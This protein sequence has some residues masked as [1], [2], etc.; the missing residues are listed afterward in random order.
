MG[1]AKMHDGQI[2][3]TNGLMRRL[4]ESQFP[5][6]SALTIRSVQ[7]SGTDH[8]LYRVGQ[9]LVARLPIVDWAVDQVD[10]DQRWLPVLA[11]HLTLRVPVP[12]AVGQPGEGYPWP[13]LVV[14][15]IAGETPDRDNLDPGPAAVSLAR[16]VASL[17][18]IHLAGGPVK[19]GTSRGVP[20][21]NL[22]PGIRPLIEGLPADI[23]KAAVTRVWEAALSAPRWQRPLV[24]IHG[25]LAPGNLIVRARSLAAVIDFSGLG[26]GDPAPDLAPAG[27]S[28]TAKPGRSSGTPSGMTM[29]PG[30]GGRAGCWLRHSRDCATTATAAP[31]SPPPLVTGSRRCSPTGPESPDPLQRVACRRQVRTEG[32]SGPYRGC[33]GSSPTGRVRFPPTGSASPHPDRQVSGPD[34]GRSAR[35]ASWPRPTRTRGRGTTGSSG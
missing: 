9:D 33:A 30:H 5:H 29:R 23:D 17:H 32:A 10:S 11:P 7:E 14:P 20:L 31:T 26:L 21:A 18:G 35:C 3:T 25:D 34:A 15:W 8:A 4:L 22:D 6:W 27:T 12:V 28:S 1:A 19:S 24:W 16:F 2:E 13:W